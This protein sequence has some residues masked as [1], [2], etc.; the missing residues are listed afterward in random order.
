MLLAPPKA[1]FRLTE[2]EWD[3]S[4]GG[5]RHRKVCFT[6]KVDYKDAAPA[7]RGG[8]EG[9]SSLEDSPTLVQEGADP[10]FTLEEDEDS[11]GE[12]AL[13]KETM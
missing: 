1:G 5:L 7:Q 11:E 12:T 4:D 13:T 2:E 3:Q 8:G 9:H 10:V 6:E